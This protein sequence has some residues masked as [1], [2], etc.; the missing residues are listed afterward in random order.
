MFCNLPT[1][2]EIIYLHGP[3]P[4][5]IFREFADRVRFVNGAEAEFMNKPSL[6]QMRSKLLIIDDCYAEISKKDKDLIRWIFCTLNHHA[7][8]SCLLLLHHMYSHTVPHLREI[9]LNVNF[10]SFSHSP[11]NKSMLKT[12][13]V[14]YYPEKWKSVLSILDY[15]FSQSRFSY[16]TF[17]FSPFKNERFRI[18]TY[19]TP[20]EAEGHRCFYIFKDT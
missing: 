10:F 2:L 17:D 7:N 5:E 20:E 19:L 16:V 6:S 14:Q 12:W 11:A 8:N 4:Q 3:T 9:M 1:D 13:A 15:A 18:S